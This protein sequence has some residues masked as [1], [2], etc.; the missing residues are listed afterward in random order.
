M[1]FMVWSSSVF[2]ASRVN[3]MPDRQ[4][5]PSVSLPV[6]GNAGNSGGIGNGSANGETYTWSFSA[7]A[8][9]SV[10]HDGSLTGTVGN[11]HHITENVTFTLLNGTRELITAT[12]T[13]DDGSWLVWACMQWQLGLI[14]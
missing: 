2:A 14:M 13:V 1:V 12:L 6:F 7:N 4:V 8:D 3:V 5:R 11:D 9:V 10:A